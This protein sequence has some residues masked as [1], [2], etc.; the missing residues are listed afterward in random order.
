MN[1]PPPACQGLGCAP[2]T[3]EVSV[4]TGANLRLSE[5][6]RVAR[7][8]ERIVVVDETAQLIEKISWFPGA[9]RMLE[10]FA[11]RFEA[12]LALLPAEAVDVESKELMDG[13]LYCL[14]FRKPSASAPG[15]GVEGA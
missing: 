10:R 9:R 6:M 12:P 14:C 5:M 15:E 2:R 1:V 8:G 11:D 4:G 7:P 13:G 3:L